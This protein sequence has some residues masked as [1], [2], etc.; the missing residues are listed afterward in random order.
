MLQSRDFIFKKL[1]SVLIIFG[2]IYLF[3]IFQLLSNPLSAQHENYSVG[4]SYTGM[5]NSSVMLSSIWSVCHNQAGLANLKGLSAGVYY[6]N[7]FFVKE[8]SLKSAA[9]AVPTHSGNFALSFTYFGFSNY[10]E[11]KIG[12]AYARDLGKFLTAG[13]QLGYVYTH[14]ADIY[15]TKGAPVAEIGLQ[16]EPLKD[17][18]IGVHLYN[19]WRAK[20]ADYQD[21]RIP[22]IFRFGIG[23]RFAS[24]VTL[25]SEIEKNLDVTTIL[26][27][28]MELELVKNLFFRTGIVN[29]PIMNTFGMGYN[30]NGLQFDLS[31]SKHQ[32]LGYSTQASLSYTLKKKEQTVNK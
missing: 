18:L 32:I 27:V 19:P 24:K 2:K 30:F 29:H 15:G 6:E 10:N 12:L 8:L 7:R 22:T 31:F 3:S 14:L 21:E 17:L 9:I 16:S 20:I 11:T 23:Y 26:K 28:G 4:A 25:T 13:I 5:A 1:R